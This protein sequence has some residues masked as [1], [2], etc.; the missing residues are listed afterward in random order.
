MRLLSIVGARPQFI[1]LA[2][3]CRAI[4]AHNRVP[5]AMRIEHQIVDT[6]QHYDREMSQLFFDQLKVVEPQYKLAVGP[7]RAGAQLGR[8][9]ERLEPILISEHP[10]WVLVYGDTTSTLAGA[11]MASRLHLA[12]AHVEAG[13]RSWDMAM[14]EEQARLVADHLSDLLLAPSENA[15][16][17]L[18]REGIGGRADPRKRRN[19]M[20]GDTLYDAL[21]QNQCIAQ[22][23]APELLHRFQLKSGGYYL[24]TLHRAENTD[25]AE[26][27]RA[28]VTASGSLDLPVLFPVHPRTKNALAAAGIRANGRIVTATPQGYLEMLA[29][30]KNA[31]KILTDSGGVQKEAFYLGVPC[32]TLRDR[33]EW[34]E[35]VACGANRITNASP[36]AILGAVS[37]KDDR[38]WTSA[39]PY[40][41]GKAAEKILA[42]LL[43]TVAS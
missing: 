35:T 39:R 26:R 15:M 6:G 12:L 25:N 24:L 22:E 31:R 27:L 38:N 29:L 8:M 42:E 11:L 23:S 30:E 10:D 21:L 34:P 4:A 36:D 18:D 3:I 2:P 37:V 20:V 33:S 13:C 16:A 32:V 40:G 5:G 19:A 17:N 28:I 41:N 9:L 43:V 14:P 1:K 7:S